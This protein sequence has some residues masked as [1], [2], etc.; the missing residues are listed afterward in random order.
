[1]SSAETNP[2]PSLSTNRQN[3]VAP[4]PKGKGERDEARVG[5]NDDV[6]FSDSAV[7]PGSR[8]ASCASSVT[9][10]NRDDRDNEEDEA[11]GEEEDNEEAEGEEDNP[12]VEPFII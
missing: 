8:P 3:I 6:V 2:S 12:S 9:P 7:P 1:M 5:G 4:G 11:E 10:S